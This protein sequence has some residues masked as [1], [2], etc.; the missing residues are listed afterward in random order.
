MNDVSADELQTIQQMRY[1]ELQK[2]KTQLREQDQ[3]WQDVSAFF[4]IPLGGSRR[5]LQQTEFGWQ[6]LHLVPI[7]SRRW[8]GT[9]V[10]FSF[11]SFS[12]R[13]DG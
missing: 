5:R 1:E 12:Q 11:R 9:W 2:I 6:P 13:E 3:Q 8:D 7:S 4:A 10:G